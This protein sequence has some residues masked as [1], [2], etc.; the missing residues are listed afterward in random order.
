MS[1]SITRHSAVKRLVLAAAGVVGVGAGA[2]ATGQAT[3]RSSR[4]T[5]TIT[6][7][8]QDIRTQ[9]AGPAAEGR[10][11]RRQSRAMSGEL[12]DDRRSPIGRITGTPLADGGTHLHTF[13]LGDGSIFGLALPG[14]AA[15]AVIGGTGRYAGATG[16]YTA[17]PADRMPG[18]STELTLTLTAWEA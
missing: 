4:E 7:Y 9:R 8:A 18:D 6:L 16:T 1:A 3:G 2:V 15:H 13:S 12:L 10:L 17:R 5:R 14:A 11:G